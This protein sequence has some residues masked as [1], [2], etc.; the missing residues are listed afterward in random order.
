VRLQRQGRGVRWCH[1]VHISPVRVELPADGK[2]REGLTLKRDP[3]S[4]PSRRCPSHRG[5]T[6]CGRKRT[7]RRAPLFSSAPLRTRLSKIVTRRASPLCLCLSLDLSLSSALSALTNT[8]QVEQSDPSLSPSL[9]PLHSLGLPRRAVRAARAIATRSFD[10]P[11]GSDLDRDGVDE[12]LHKPVDGLSLHARRLWQD[13][14]SE[15][16]IGES[17]VVDHL[18]L[19][20]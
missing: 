19:V 16:L 9:S 2:S 4:S 6:L 10:R 14:Q 20:L 12:H 11:R 18:V 1:S 13:D 17:L 3:P 15:D 7:D 8:L 5:K